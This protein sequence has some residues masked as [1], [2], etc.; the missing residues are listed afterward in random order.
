MLLATF[1]CACVLQ[2]QN[3]N[4]LTAEAKQSYT[5][6]KNNL[7]KMADKMPEQDYSFKPTPEMQTFLQRMAHTANVNIGACGVI[8]GE[9][10][11]VEVTANTTK[12]E[13]VAAVR[14]SFAYCDGVFD[15]MSD[16]EATQMVNFRGGQHPKLAVL[17]AVIIH[18]NE[19]YG[20][21][22]VYMRLKGIVPP[23]SEPK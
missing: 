23:S 19:M 7:V 3:A 12:S 18:S 16:A 14:D 21:M 5:V 20:Y 1:C 10:K 17:Y 8:K 6:V 4:P 9:K 13:V 15:S 2:A 11:S 22:S